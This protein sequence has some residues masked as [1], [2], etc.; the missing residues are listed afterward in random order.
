MI[1]LIRVVD[2]NQDEYCLEALPPVESIERLNSR[3]LHPDGA[4]RTPLGRMM[5]YFGYRLGSRLIYCL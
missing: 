2:S 1:Q 3:H 4:G 5:A